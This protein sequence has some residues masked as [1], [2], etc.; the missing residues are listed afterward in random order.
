MHQ[1]AFDSLAFR[2]SE[3]HSL[4]RSSAPLQPTRVGN[5]QASIEALSE[6]KA[7]YSVQPRPAKKTVTLE[8]AVST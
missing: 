6:K 8:A 5:V 2:K 7:W 1:R 4:S 3:T